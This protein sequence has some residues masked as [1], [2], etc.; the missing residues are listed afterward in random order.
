MSI[1]LKRKGLFVSIFI[2]IVLVGFVASRYY[3]VQGDSA[4]QQDPRGSAA[5]GR[6]ANPGGQGGP[7]RGPGSGGGAG[8]RPQFVEVA[9]AKQGFLREQVSLVGSLKPK[10]QVEVMSKI[11]G[12]VTRIL[13]QVGDPVKEGQFIAELEDDELQQQELRAEASLAVAQAT[14]AQRQAELENA[15]A[16]KD[17]GANLVEEGLIP[18][19]TWDTIQTRTRVAESQLKLAQAQVQ[20][21]TADREQLRI[22]Q[23][24]T[25]IRSPLTGYVGRRYVDPG[26]LVNPNSSIVSVLQLSTMVT[27]VNVPEQYL[28]KLRVGNRAVVAIDAF[29]GRTYEGKVARLSPL[30]DPATR[31]SLVEIEIPN[32]DGQLKAEMFARIQMD[33]GGERQ[34]LLVPREAVV[35]QGE[36]SGVHVL[37][38]DRVQFRPIQTGVSSEQGVEVLAGLELGVTVVTRGSQNLKDGDTVVVQGGPED[39]QRRRGDRS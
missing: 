3:R 35:L 15:Q 14:L 37:L 5:Q 1:S 29:G 20:Q 24:Q 6:G 28:A 8:S 19:Q 7:S 13:V 39:P 25:Q 33:L 10:E 32:A 4:G 30:L 9:T 11:A 31:S 18:S 36:Q 22:R 12:R 2:A 27:A 26:A 21:A 16:E 23:Q 34:A 17:R 38:A